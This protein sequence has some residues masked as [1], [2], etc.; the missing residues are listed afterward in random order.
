MTALARCFVVLMLVVLPIPL[1]FL[2]ASAQSTTPLVIT[3]CN[4]AANDIN[5]AL[6]Y[7]TAT[8]RDLSV[9]SNTLHGPF[10]TT[11][12]WSIYPY[13]CQKISTH[14][15]ARYVFWY[16]VADS[17]APLWEDSYNGVH[18]CVPAYPSAHFLFSGDNEL[19]NN[20]DE[21]S[22]ENGPAV[23]SGENQWVN[24]RAIDTNQTTPTA[25]YSGQ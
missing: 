19:N 8:A 22:C 3:I 21:T 5:V 9:R 23:G 15:L 2:S 11:G 17:G 20:S 4:Q 18:F 10:I 12:W 6:G 14:T 16:G 25:T 24:A 13:T 1:F 7:K